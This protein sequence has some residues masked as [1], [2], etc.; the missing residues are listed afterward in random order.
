[1]RLVAVFLALALAATQV[2]AVVTEVAHAAAMLVLLLLQA[3]AAYALQL[4]DSR[5]G[6]AADM[7]G[8]FSNNA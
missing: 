1:M 8:S 4:P 5:T 6:N 3:A 2:I 7:H